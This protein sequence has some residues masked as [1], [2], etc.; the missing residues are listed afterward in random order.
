M[1][2][3]E[4]ARGL[5]V[6]HMEACSQLDVK[7]THRI[8]RPY[9]YFGQRDEIATALEG[10]LQE[11]VAGKQFEVSHEGRDSYLVKRVM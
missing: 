2:V 6:E 4:L 11:F 5:A 1:E 8:D 10:Y 3:S 9:G 7:K